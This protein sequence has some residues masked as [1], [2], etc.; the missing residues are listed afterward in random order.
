MAFGQGATVITPIEQAVAYSTFANGGTRYAPQVAAAIVSPTG[1]VVK[2]FAPKVTGHVNLPPTTYD[3]LLAGFTARSTTRAAP[4]TGPSRGSTS[5][6][7]WPARPG[8]PTARSARS[9]PPG[10]SASVPPPPP[11]TWWCA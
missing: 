1:K 5:P 9:P 4:P 8:P 6:A 3:A 11:S 2:R 10:S 7:A